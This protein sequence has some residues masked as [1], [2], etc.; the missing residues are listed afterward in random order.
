MDMIYDESLPMEL[1]NIVRKKP[2]NNNSKNSSIQR[3]IENDKPECSK[4]FR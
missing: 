4:A 2:I 3:K 1:S